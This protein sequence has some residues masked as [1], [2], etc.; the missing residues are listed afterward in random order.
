MALTACAPMVASFGPQERQPAITDDAFVTRDGLRL[1]MRHWDAK[2]A[3]RAIVL[4]L[5]GMSD[6]SNAFAM[7][8]AYW[9]AKGISTYAYDQ[10]GFGRSP[11]PGIWPGSA[12]LKSDLTDCAMALH[13]RFPGKPLIILGESM[14]GAVVLSAL[15]GPDPPRADG[16]VLVAPAVWSRSDMPLSYRTALWLAAHVVPSLRLSGNGL[17]IWPSDNIA[18]LRK[19]AHDPLF[20]HST[21][22]D[23]VYGLVD[24]MDEARRSPVL[25]VDPPPIL[26]L[27]GKHDQIIP[28]EPTEAVT[29]ALA[30]HAEVHRYDNGY[31]M[32]L[33]DLEGPIVWKGVADWIDK[34]PQA[35]HS[36]SAATAT[37]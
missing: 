8:A 15:A 33:R 36:V 32:L 29:A 10:R 31:H 24:L 25:I 11:Q 1:P 4:A 35:S 20:Q 26:F 28:A 9:T 16:V 7:P 37:P 23:A 12:K 6:Y 30:G 21:R 34:L 18:M 3:I 5:H 27:Y 14:G 2:G 22:A 19:L 17:R 13:Q